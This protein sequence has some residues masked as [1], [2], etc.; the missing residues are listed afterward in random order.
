LFIAHIV[1]DSESGWPCTM[2]AIADGIVL[3]AVDGAAA[4]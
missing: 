4:A 1:Q 2:T 3:D